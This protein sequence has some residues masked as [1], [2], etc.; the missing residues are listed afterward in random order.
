MCHSNS[1]SIGVLRFRVLPPG[2]LGRD[3]VPVPWGWQLGVVRLPQRGVRDPRGV[4]MRCW[5]T[6]R[7]SQPLCHHAPWLCP[8]LVRVGVPLC[9][10]RPSSSPPQSQHI[11]QLVLCQ[12]P[13]RGHPLPSRGSFDGLCG[14][15]AEPGDLA[16]W[17]CQ[18][19]LS[20]PGARGGVPREQP[21]MCSTGRERHGSQGTGVKF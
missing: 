9:C 4:L 14:G 19:A 3:G 16:M 17:L 21:G 1:P 6:L 10:L 5:W 7:V 2:C 20:L 8:D 11:C 13:Q 18:R 12:I 15:G